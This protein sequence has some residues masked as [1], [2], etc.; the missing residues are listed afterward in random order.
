MLVLGCYEG[1]LRPQLS[2]EAS[3]A[4]VLGSSQVHPWQLVFSSQR[5]PVQPAL[6]TS[7]L[8]DPGGVGGNAGCSRK[9][10]G[11]LLWGSEAGGVSS[12]FIMELLMG[13]RAKSLPGLR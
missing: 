11:D 6:P 8:V 12:T 7:M 1:T 4:K 3:D 9:S 5:H 13:Q 10:L 2:H